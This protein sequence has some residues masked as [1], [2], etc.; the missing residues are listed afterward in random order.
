MN[1]AGLSGCGLSSYGLT[2]Y[3]LGQGRWPSASIQAVTH[4][5]ISP[6]SSASSCWN[7][8]GAGTKPFF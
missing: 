3:D 6:V 4:F 2:N 8:S 5:G 1:L 7:T